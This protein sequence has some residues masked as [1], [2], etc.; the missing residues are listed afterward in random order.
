MRDFQRARVYATDKP[1]NGYRLQSADAVCTFIGRILRSAW[2]RKRSAVRKVEVREVSRARYYSADRETR[3]RGYVVLR[4][5]AK[6]HDEGVILHELAHILTPVN[7]SV[8]GAEF[9][10]NY[11]NLVLKWMG[12][13]AFC[14]LKSRFTEGGVQY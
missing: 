1:F 12:P 14:D 8:H 4:G 13:E 9:C 10:R 11:L 6:T 2:W 7:V 5:D 3:Y